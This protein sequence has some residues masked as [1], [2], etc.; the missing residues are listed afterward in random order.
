MLGPIIGPIVII[1]WPK[2][3]IYWSYGVTKAVAII[4]NL[5]IKATDSL[6][7]ITFWLLLIRK[8]AIAVTI[9]VTIAV[10]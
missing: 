2:P 7:V 6:Q 4:R 5:K 10:T 9:T 1:D 8:I 3:T